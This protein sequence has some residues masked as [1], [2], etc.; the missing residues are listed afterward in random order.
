MWTFIENNE[1]IPF[2]IKRVFYVYDVPTAESRGAH[3]HKTLEQFLICLSGSFDV[4]LDDGK[5]KKK[6]H[7]NRPWEGL[8][9]PPMIWAAE[10]NFDPG[11][12]CLVLC[13]A[14]YCKDDYIRDYEIFKEKCKITV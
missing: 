2:S 1:H 4:E 11:T 5:K 6:V 3:A 7:L 14:L 10:T 13:S 9:I 8:Y 12:V